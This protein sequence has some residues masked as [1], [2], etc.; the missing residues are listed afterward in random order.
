MTIDASAHYPHLVT[1]HFKPT[2]LERIFGYREQ[3]RFA[4]LHRSIGGSWEWR[5]D[6]DDKPLDAAS[7]RAVERAVRELAQHR[8]SLEWRRIWNALPDRSAEP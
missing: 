6:H 3:E 4:A 2:W 5:W 1:V 8:V 7:L